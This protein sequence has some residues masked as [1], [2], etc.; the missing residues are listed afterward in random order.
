M[1]DALTYQ[2]KTVRIENAAV[3]GTTD[4]EGDTID[5]AGYDAVRCIALL[6]TLTTGH[7]TKLI[8]KGGALANGSDGVAITGADSGVAADADSNHMLILDVIQPQQ[9]YITFVLDRGTQNAVLDGMLVELYKARA[10]PVD[11]DGT[12]TAQAVVVPTA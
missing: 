8:A 4:V 10:T 7:A 3:A 2:V 5:M 1:N 6:G 11:M 9:R 12:V